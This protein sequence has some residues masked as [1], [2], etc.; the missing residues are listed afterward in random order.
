MWEEELSG[1]AE[2]LLGSVVALGREYPGGDVPDRF[3]WGADADLDY[4]TYVDVA[5]EL[6][7]KGLAES[8]GGTDF[9]SLK[10]TPKGRAL[11]REI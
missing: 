6:V 3:L 4:D 2:L 7:G 5:A 1:N 10:A 9:P 8:P 11:F